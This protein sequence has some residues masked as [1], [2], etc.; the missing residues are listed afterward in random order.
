MQRF[1]LKQISL[2]IVTAKCSVC[3][4]I[5]STSIPEVGI[6]TESG[7]E[8]ESLRSPEM[9][10]QKLDTSNTQPLSMDIK[11]KDPAPEEAWQAVFMPAHDTAST[12]PA[13][14]L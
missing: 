4:P 13:H 10:K 12:R 11:T 7:C 14:T 3:I 5:F 2:W 8:G 9:E 6:K 1:A